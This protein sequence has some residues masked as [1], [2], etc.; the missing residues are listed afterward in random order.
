MNLKLLLQH[1]KLVSV[2]KARY[3]TYSKLRHAVSA[4]V[5]RFHHHPVYQPDMIPASDFG[6]E[7]HGFT[8]LNRELAGWTAGLN[9]N[10]DEYEYLYRAI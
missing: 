4:G 8:L 1:R 6:I 2:V 5:K 9:P 3:Q 7:T 10:S